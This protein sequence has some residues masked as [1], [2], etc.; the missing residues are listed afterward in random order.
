MW[1][2]PVCAVTM[3]LLPTVNKEADLAGSQTE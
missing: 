2:A 1:D 3:F